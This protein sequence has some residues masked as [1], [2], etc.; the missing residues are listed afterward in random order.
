VVPSRASAALSHPRPDQQSRRR[1]RLWSLTCARGRGTTSWQSP[2]GWASAN[3]H[4]GEHNPRDKDPR[5]GGLR[6]S[7]EA[8][9]DAQQVEHRATRRAPRR[10]SRP[11]RVHHDRDGTRN[12]SQGRRTR[13]GTVAARANASGTSPW[14]TSHG[15][16]PLRQHT[17]T[18]MHYGKSTTGKCHCTGSEFVTIS[19]K[20]VRE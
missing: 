3:G 5:E 1:Y 4:D 7:H 9:T 16:I 19:N 2:R 17:V 20:W 18:E 14:Y 13:G 8:Q 12:T 15:C 6:T 10:L 11:K